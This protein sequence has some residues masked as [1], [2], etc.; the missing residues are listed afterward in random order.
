MGQKQSA[1]NSSTSGAR[2]NTKS[3]ERQIIDQ[4][5][6]FKLERYKYILEQ[7]HALNEN[8]HKYLALFQTLA[9]VIIGG[10]ITLF[11]SWRG[12]KISADVART[13]MQ[14][15]LGLL[16]IIALFVVLSLLGGIFSWLDYRREEVELL[17]EAVEPGFREPPRAGNFWRWYET[18]V[19]LFILII[20]M[21]VSIF[22][23]TQVVPLIR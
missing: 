18:Y 9:T 16:I 11:V 19:I 7:I 12:L 23:E 2:S 1:V 21:L 3:D 10:G 22:V 17:N 5:N 14:G 4:G 6:D 13:G 8:V 20:I 15:L